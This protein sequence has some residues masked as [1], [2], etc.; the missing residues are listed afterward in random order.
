MRKYILTEQE[1][2]I[3][4]RFLETGD[5]LEGF[6][7]LLC[8]SKNI[9]KVNLDLELIKKFLAKVESSRAL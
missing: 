1:K 9:E 6:R 4:N 7:M 8:R 3:I 2:T 5:R